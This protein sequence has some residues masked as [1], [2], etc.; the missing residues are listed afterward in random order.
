[1]NETL[2]KMDI[3]TRP[4]TVKALKDVQWIKKE[5]HAYGENAGK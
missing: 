3:S 1:M 5:V 2:L 4:G